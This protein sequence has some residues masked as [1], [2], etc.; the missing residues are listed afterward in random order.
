MTSA[1]FTV[2]ARALRVIAA[3][4]RAQL[5]G[6]CDESGQWLATL[7]ARTARPP[8]DPRADDNAPKRV[9]RNI[10]APGGCTFYWDQPLLR[11]ARVLSRR[12]GDP[13]WAEAAS[14]YTQAFLRNCRAANGLFLWGNHY[15]WSAR[16]QRV[17]RFLT[18]EPPLPVMAEETG[19]LHEM[20]PLFP[21]WDLLWSVDAAAT[22]RHIRMSARLHTIDPGTGEFNRHA[23]RGHSPHPPHAFLESGAVL[24][25]ALSWLHTRTG[26]VDLLEQADA[27]A[28]YLFRH[29]D[30][31]TGLLPTCPNSPPRRWD[32][33]TATTECGFW[34]DALL[35]AAERAPTPYKRRW[36][37]M[38][39]ETMEAWLAVAW[40]AEAGRFFG[41]VATDSGHP[42][43]A[44]AGSSPYQP[45][46]HSNPWVGLFPRHDYPMETATVCLRLFRLTGRSL[47]RE[48]VFRWLDLLSRDITSGE[49]TRCGSEQLGKTL[50]FARPCARAFPTSAA[51][52]MVGIIQSLEHAAFALCEGTP[53]FRSHPAGTFHRAVGGTGFLFSALI[54]D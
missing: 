18:D 41:Q 52:D 6:G 43:R 48:A 1:W 53:L 51:S 2:R 13:A 20:R 54:H 34:A 21:D 39:A 35:T 49:Q 42:L 8:A 45:G 15:F 36:E 9:Y 44:P 30:P 17:V 50:A 10:D 25:D 4:F 40:D 3:H 33:T 37:T 28:T 16:H 12:T 14:A 23:D 24:I 27:F 7:D 11:A 26:Y 46:F 5:V 32:R 47:Y 19:G 29:R 31:R 22:A 38:A